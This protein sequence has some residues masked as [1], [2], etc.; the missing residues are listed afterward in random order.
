MVVEPDPH[1]GDQAR[2]ETA[3]P[4]VA[5]V[6]GRAGL[7]G[8]VG[9]LEHERLA[10]GAATDH[11]AQNGLEDPVVAGRHHPGSHHG[12]LLLHGAAPAFP[13]H[14]CR[15]RREHRFP[16]PVLN[17]VEEPG[18]HRVPA[19]GEHR[20]GGGGLE[21]RDLAAPE[22]EGEAVRQ[23]LPIET[24]ALDVV[25]GEVHADLAQQADRDQV[26]RLDERFSQPGRPEELA[27]VVLGPPHGLEGGVVEH[28]R[29]V[30]DQARGGEA[31]REGRRVDEGLEAGSGLPAGLGPA[32]EL[33]ATEVEAS[34]HREDGPVRG[35]HGDEGALDL[36]DL[37]ELPPPCGPEHPDA[38]SRG[39]HVRC[40]LGRWPP[41][42]DVHVGSRP[43]DALEGEDDLALAANVHRRLLRPGPSDQG[44][45]E[46]ADRRHVLEQ[47]FDSGRVR[48]AFEFVPVFR[49]AVAMAPV[50]LDE[51]FAK[52][53]HRRRLEAAVDRRH[54]AVG[55]GVG[56][57][58]ELPLDLPADHLGNVWG[59]GLGGRGVA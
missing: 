39:Q 54:D 4:R 43:F 59:L 42:V 47:G 28:H 44:G 3:E 51:G 1:D 30:V 57:R 15:R 5:L 49:P 48:R 20:V 19:V 23:T 26:A 50:V 34:R 22:G 24:E 38:V 45:Q 17:P 36:R 10:A 9:A 7:P 31:P 14:P 58:P 41:A 40:L 27:A 46:P 25:E 16:A 56:G 6:V 35:V 12:S 37:G 21:R 52:G 33:A 13:A 55:G 11:V 18:T 2:H 32:V 8:E 53:A 29:G